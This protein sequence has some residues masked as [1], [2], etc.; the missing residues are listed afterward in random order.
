MLQGNQS[1]DILFDS[2]LIYLEISFL[3]SRS[4]LNYQSTRNKY[5]STGV[6]QS[7]DMTYQSTDGVQFGLIGCLCFETE[8]EPN[9]LKKLI[10]KKKSNFQLNR[11]ELPIL[12][13]LVSLVGLTELLHDPN[14]I[15]KIH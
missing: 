2:R 10:F 12:I 14:W 13:G 7:T 5:Q 4:R 8:I 1:N 15:H 9:K 3:D 11:T 6:H